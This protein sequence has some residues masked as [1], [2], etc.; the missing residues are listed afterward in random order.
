MARKAV[1]SKEHVPPTL[2]AQRAIELIERQLQQFD[3]VIRLRRDDPQVDKWTSTTEQILKAAF[4]EP[5]GNDHDMLRRFKSAGAIYAFSTGTPDSYF[6]EIYREGMA[7]KKAILESCLDQLHIFAP[8]IAQVAPGQYQFHP[9]IE[10][11]SGDLFRD[12][13]YKQA[14]LEAYIRVIEDV[15]QRSSLALDG[16]NLMNQAFGCTNRSPV[17]RFNSL[18]TDAERDEQNGFMFVFKGIVGLR[19]SKAHS[20]RLFNDPMRAHEYLAMASVLMRL[21]EIAQK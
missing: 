12:G 4:G 5:H 17:L 3:T 15:K 13:H 19:N 10:R 1:P 9:E 8:P 18:S 16:D 2:T 20:N 21:L 7:T 6:E 14:A 11:V